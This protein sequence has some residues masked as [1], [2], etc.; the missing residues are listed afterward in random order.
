LSIEERNVESTEK[1]NAHL[2]PEKGLSVWV[3]GGQLL[4][5]KVRSEQ[6]GGAYSLFEGLVPAHDGTPPHIHHR[7]D[8]CFY[9]LEGEF[10]FSVG[11][12]TLLAEAGTLVYI[13]RGTLHAFRNVGEEPGRLL[14]S[15]TPGGL[16]ERFF[17]EAGEAAA[18]TRIPP[19][20]KGSPDFERIAAIAAK[21]GTE[22]P[23]VS[24]A[25]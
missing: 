19:V 15:Q 25:A 8:E 21:Y 2:G 20:P 18:D 22:I 12:D 1:S 10:E 23:P 16:H 13:P 11:D 14:I 4:T 9:V 5:Y 17:E 6:T 7:E 24:P 3:F